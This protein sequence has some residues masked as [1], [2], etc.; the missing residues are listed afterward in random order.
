MATIAHIGIDLAKYVIQVHGID[1]NGKVLLKKMVKR[2]E[3][4]KTI[5]N[6]EPCVIGMEACGGAHYWARRFSEFGHEVKLMAAQFVAPYRKNQK[7]DANDAEA[8]CEALTRPSMRFVPK[9]SVDQ[10]V[11]LSLHRTRALLVGQRTAI[12]NHMRGLLLEFGIAIS[13]GI[14]KARNQLPGILE[15]GDNELPDIVRELIAHNVQHLKLLDA[16]IGDLDK[17][18]DHLAKQSEL[19]QRILKIEGIGPLCA[20]AMIASIGD[21]KLFNNGRQLA[22]WLGLTP[23][24]YS[25]GG[26]TRLGRITKGG[27]RYLRTLLIQGAK[28]ALFQCARKKDQKSHWAMQIRE[29]RNHNIAVVA[30][31]AKN[32]RTIWALLAKNREYQHDYQPMAA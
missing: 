15:D 31:A 30:L 32:A 4:I 13:R 21:A 26:K 23:K 10:Q 20:T 28:S 27:N 17:Q 25:S 11:V 7:N 12:V 29:R 3:L 14:Q 18:L 5:M 8:I 24:Q 2:S 16:R 9:K 22:A 1:A 6:I 19:S